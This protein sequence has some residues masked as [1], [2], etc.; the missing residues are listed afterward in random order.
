PDVFIKMAAERTRNIR[1]GACVSSLSS[2]HPLVLADRIMQLDHV[3]RGRVALCAGPVALPFDTD[4]MG[5]RP[6]EQTQAMRCAI[7]VL[8]PL[9]KGEQVS[10]KTRWFELDEARLQLSPYSK[11]MVEDE[12]RL[13]LPPYSKP[14]VEMAVAAQTSPAGASMAGSYGLGLISIGATSPGGFNALAPS[15]EIYERKALGNNH[16]VDRKRWSLAGPVHIAETREQAFDNVRYGLGEWVRYFQEVV[17]LP[18]VSV[19]CDDPARELVNSGLAVIGAPE[20]AIAQICRL[21]EQSGGFGCFL[22]LAHHW[23]DPA[24]TRK[25]YELFMQYVKPEMGA[26]NGEIARSLGFTGSEEDAFGNS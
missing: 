16:P 19:E 21:Q 2:Q 25:S 9:L 24:A 26:H 5:V 4:M 15:W 1:L 3:T 6:E 23:A 18:L 20:D 22:Q 10:S 8:V 12:A 7:E 13:Q 17:S 14:M 11:P